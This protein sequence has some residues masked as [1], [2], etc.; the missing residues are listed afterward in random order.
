MD[1]IDKRLW[2]NI[3]FLNAQIW[4]YSNTLLQSYS[5]QNPNSSC[6]CHTWWKSWM[7]NNIYFPYQKDFCTPPRF[8][9][10]MVTAKLPVWKSP[11]VKS[12]IHRRRAPLFPTC[13]SEPQS[14]AGLRG[15]GVTPG[16][17]RCCH[18][19]C[20]PAGDAA[21]PQEQGRRLVSQAAHSIQMLLWLFI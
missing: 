18:P 19:S 2:W 16:L 9:T 17:R 8:S 15:A 20:C 7:W 3:Y 1:D 4:H 14:F 6:V 21:K 12:D 11:K 5:G 10:Q 13:P